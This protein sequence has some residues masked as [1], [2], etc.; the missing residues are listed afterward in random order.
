MLANK[1]EIIV[2]NKMDLT[3]AE[4]RLE[5]F[6]EKVGKQVHPISAVTGRGVAELTELAWQMVQESKQLA[7]DV[8]ENSTENLAEDI[9]TGEN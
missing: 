3:G 2:A 8:E 5:E 9:S 7:E 4:G 6:R 1:P